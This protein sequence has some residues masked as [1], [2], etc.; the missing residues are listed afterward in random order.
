MNRSCFAGLGFILVSTLALVAGA[1]DR[2]FTYTYET[3][4][5][6]P[7]HAEIEPWVTYRTGRDEHFNR[8]DLRLEYE[9]GVV[10]GLQ[11]ALYLNFAAQSEDQ[12]D[13]LTQERFRQQSFAFTGVSSEWK[14]QLT[15]PVADPIG[16]ALYLEGTFAPQRTELEAKVLLDKRVGPFVT[17]MNLVGE[18]EWEYP[19][20]EETTRY[21]QVEVDLAAGVEA[22]K[23]LVVGVEVNAPTH[24]PESGPTSSVVNL[25]PALAAHLDRWW[26]ATTFLMQ[27]A[28]LK[29][30]TSGNLN[31]ERYERFQVRTIWGFHL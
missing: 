11:T 12:F 9:G 15:D 19:S 8:Y 25:G 14:Y 20:H 24:L 29:N 28:A 4:V 21:A 6:E 7:G 16:S 2:S 3:P 30:P 27:V 17:A 13:E 5:A 23:A 26:V 10:R 1:T 31:L 22:T 18:Y